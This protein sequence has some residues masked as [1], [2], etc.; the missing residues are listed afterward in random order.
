MLLRGRPVGRLLRT[1]G[2]RGLRP[3]V[4]WRFLAA[5]SCQR[6]LL[7]LNILWMPANWLATIML[8]RSPDGYVEAGQLGAAYQWFAALLLP[9]V[10]GFSTLPLLSQHGRDSEGFARTRRLALHSTLVA[11]LPL[12][13]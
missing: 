6:A 5:A 13:L 2:L 3:A 8:V 12:A 9:N 10:L 1:K 7:L 4:R 11:A